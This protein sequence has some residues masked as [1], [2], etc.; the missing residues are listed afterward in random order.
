MK[1]LKK[2]YFTCC[3]L[4]LLSFVACNI[5]APIIGKL[6]GYQIEELNIREIKLKIWLPIENPNNIKFNIS[7][8]DLD[9]YVNGL[10]LGKITRMEKVHIPKKSKKIYAIKLDVK[11]KDLGVSALSALNQLR[12]KHV[13]LKIDGDITV[14]KFV[15]IK[16]V[17]VDV[18]NKVEIW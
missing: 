13:M 14:S 10:K 4:I 1:Y 18:E 6:S 7:N 9:I 5:Q 17:E 15:I 3:L 12:S 2:A 8:V 16:K 11:M